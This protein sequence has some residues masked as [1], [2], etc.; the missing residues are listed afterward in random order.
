MSEKLIANASALKSGNRWRLSR[1]RFLAA[2][3]P[4]VLAAK[5]ALADRTHGEFLQSSTEL[6]AQKLAWAGVKLE[7]PSMT[8]FID[9]LI[10]H[11]VWGDALK[12]PIVPVES[13]TIRRQ[14]LITHLH[15]DHF[16]EAAVKKIL[17]EGGNLIC[18][19]ESAAIAA[20]RG[21]RVRAAKLY[22]PMLF[23]DFT[24]TAVPAAD[25]Y[26]DDQVSWIV[27]GGGRKIIHC[28]DTMWHGSYWKIGRQHGPFDAAFLPINGAKFSWLKPQSD[29]PA[30]LTPEQAVA[31]GVVLGA[32]LAVPIHYGVSGAASYEEQ[33]NAEAAFIEIARKHNLSVEVAKPG[34]W[35][36]WKANA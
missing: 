20:S 36:K 16:D 30:V 21:F 35:L 17:A 31:A 11:E 27:T 22:E 24:I 1:R 28:G 14:V 3:A 7:I 2:G 6:K 8:L 13:A 10:S 26:G 25:G 34:E 9:P 32:R 23:G 15:N 19:I 33:A 12:Q 29:I 4:L 5:N 18:H